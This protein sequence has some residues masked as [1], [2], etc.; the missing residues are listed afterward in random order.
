MTLRARDRV[1]R[2]LSLRHAPERFLAFPV[3]LA[4]LLRRILHLLFQPFRAGAELVQ[5]RRRSRT[6][7]GGTATARKDEEKG[8][9]GEDGREEDPALACSVTRPEPDRPARPEPLQAAGSRHR[10]RR[11][12]SRL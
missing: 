2:G 3:R 1:D 10:L 11:F 7:S 12:A 4:F 9:R 8:Y 5:F 6:R